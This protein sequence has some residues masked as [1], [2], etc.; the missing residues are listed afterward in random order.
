MNSASSATA[1]AT[2][3]VIKDA[4]F[5]EI[6]SIIWEYCRQAGTTSDNLTLG[7]FKDWLTMNHLGVK[8]WE[9]LDRYKIDRR[10]Q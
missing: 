7:G 3:T 9:I 8:G 1:T 10:L 6:R 4:T 5:M 2:A